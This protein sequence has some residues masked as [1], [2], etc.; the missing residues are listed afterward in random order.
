MRGFPILSSNVHLACSIAAVDRQGYKLPEDMI[1]RGKG[2]TVFR[3]ALAGA[4]ALAAL[5]AC[6]VKPNEAENG[7]TAATSAAS[8]ETANPTAAAPAPAPAPINAIQTQPGPN[9][10]SA[11]LERVAVT[12]NI[13][14]V[15]LRLTGG[16]HD[17][18][19]AKLEEISVIDDATSNR[20]GVLKDSEGKWMASPLFAANNVQL[21]TGRDTPSLVWLK[22]PAP[23]ATSPTISINIP[24]IA[25]FDGVPVTR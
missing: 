21:L 23:P 25:P 8:A 13:M 6:N 12:G 19:L 18:E 3:T 15:Q 9:G 4:A 22:F 5:S 17:S 10:S 20:I 1:A 7:A 16:S 11:I 14:T 2:M 24:G